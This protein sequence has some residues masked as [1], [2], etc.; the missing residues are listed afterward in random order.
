MAKQ[1]VE[2]IAPYQ[3]LYRDPE[4]GIA[5]V[6]DG[7]CGLGYSCHGNISVTGSVRGMRDRGYW[8]RKD[9][10]VRSHG[11][12]YNVDTLVI[13]SPLDQK[14]ADACQCVGCLERRAR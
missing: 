5:W 14:A 6:E 11:W 4:T 8:G 13:T 7:T 12:A 3:A 2:Q 9:R 10:V 1:L